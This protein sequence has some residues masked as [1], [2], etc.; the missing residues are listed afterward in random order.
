MKIAMYIVQT[1]VYRNRRKISKHYD[2]KKKKCQSIVYFF[3]ILFS[4]LKG[5]SRVKITYQEVK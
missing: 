1:K 3:S 2:K 5:R 4:Q